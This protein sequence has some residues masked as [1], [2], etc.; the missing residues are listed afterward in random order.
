MAVGQ[1]VAAPSATE[2]SDLRPYF[3]VLESYLSGAIDDSQFEHHYTHMFRGDST[4]RPGD[5]VDVLNSIFGDV[6]QHMNMHLMMEGK[7]DNSQ[8]RQR[9]QAAYD[10]L[11][12]MVGAS[13]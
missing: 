8:L 7:A 6:D 12:E 13:A 11:K 4:L 9:A 3:D 5:E 2:G 1:P 10:R